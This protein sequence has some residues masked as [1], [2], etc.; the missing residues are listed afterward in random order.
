[1]PFWYQLSKKK[2]VTIFL[3]NIEMVPNHLFT[4]FYI[5]IEFKVRLYT[6]RTRPTLT[7]TRLLS[8]FAIQIEHELE[9]G[10]PSTDYIAARLL[11]L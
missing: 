9:R 3:A 10:K 5:I 11:L 4:H 6:A 1:M 2:Y 8:G 7:R